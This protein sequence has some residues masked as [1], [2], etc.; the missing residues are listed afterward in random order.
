MISTYNYIKKNL[1]KYYSIKYI[2]NCVYV[3]QLLIFKMFNKYFF[4]KT[5][6]F[7]ITFSSFLDNKNNFYQ[8]NIIQK[9]IKIQKRNFD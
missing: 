3:P 8:H 9:K 1:K 5:T 4:S 2:K 7:S 6:G